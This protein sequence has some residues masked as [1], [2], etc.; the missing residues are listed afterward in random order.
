LI[1]LAA[2]FS[3][4]SDN[5]NLLSISTN[6][7]KLC[8]W[9]WCGVFGELYGSANETRYALDMTG[10]FDWINGVQQPDTVTRA[11]FEATRL[12]SMQ[13]RNSAAYKGVLALIMQDSPLDFMSA[14]RMDIASYS[15]ESTDIHHIFPKTYCISKSFSKD[16]WDSVI[17]KT[18]IY[19]ST[20]RSIGGRAPSEYIK[21]MEN[22][23]L[24]EQQI[25]EAIASHFINPQL[26]RTDAFDDFIVDRAIRLLDRI[27]IAMGKATSG[28][29]SEDTIR[30][31]GADLKKI[32]EINEVSDFESC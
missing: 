22:K 10:I 20:N 16:K 1:P 9:Y 24:N 28:R 27:E 14:N 32:R 23:G 30:E 26:L 17:N 21:T 6:K 11:N 31:F 2:I 8:K 29:E 12:L 4:D 25:D 3:Y 7:E 15:N 19:A 18:L 5:G 13:T